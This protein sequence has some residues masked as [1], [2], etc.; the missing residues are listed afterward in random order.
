MLEFASETQF[1]NTYQKYYQLDTN[2]SFTAE[3]LS[4]LPTRDS[5]QHDIEH[6][7]LDILEAKISNFT[8]LRKA[9][10]K[11]FEDFLKLGNEPDDYDGD[12]IYDTYSASLL[13]SD[14]EVKIG[15]R[16]FKFYPNGRYIVVAGSD[17]TEF[18]AAR[19]QPFSALF[20]KGNLLLSDITYSDSIRNEFLIVRRTISTPPPVNSPCEIRFTLSA[21][22]DQFG[23][24]YSFNNTSIVEPCSGTTTWKWYQNG[25]LALTTTSKTSFG[26]RPID[27]Y[28]APASMRLDYVCSNGCSG[29][30]T[31][32]LTK[33]YLESN[34]EKNPAS[35]NEFSVIITSYNIANEYKIN[36]GDGN[37]E[38]VVPVGTNFINTSSKHTHFYSPT[39]GVTPFTITVSEKG[40]SCTKS[41]TFDITS[42]CG[43]KTK[44][45]KSFDQNFTA[46]G[47]SWRVEATIWK[48]HSIFDGGK[49]LGAS[50]KTYMKSSG[51]WLKKK[52]DY[53]QVESEFEFY[54]GDPSCIYQHKP[55]KLEK[56]NWANYVSTEY[57]AGIQFFDAFDLPQEMWVRATALRGGVT[58]TTGIKFYQQ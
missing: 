54:Q 28:G 43:D 45:K 16:I 10:E 51:I 17:W 7:V 24:F 48:K 4:A 3:A 55:Y 18:N 31:M 30:F 25:N 46:N 2:S 29:S 5:T 20:P 14:G 41:Q 34:L 56:N 49:N 42:Q 47:H 22:E 36:W 33:C 9:D 39:F 38:T 13:N 19:T 27:F 58:A 44:D 52:A 11:A 32:D 57:D 12:F 26:M 8:S 53:V 21:T 37:I 6:P 23:L 15:S 35:G 50:A 1:I 40:P